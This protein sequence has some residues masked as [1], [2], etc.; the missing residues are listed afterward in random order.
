MALLPMAP[1]VLPSSGMGRGG[2]LG[3]AGAGVGAVLALVDLLPF[4]SLI[5]LRIVRSMCSLIHPSIAHTDT[6]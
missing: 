2:V 6:W 4:A 3:G 1:P 5:H